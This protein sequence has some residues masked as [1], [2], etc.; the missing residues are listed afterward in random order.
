M[1]NVFVCSLCGGDVGASL[2]FGTTSF[3]GS[4]ASI[5]AFGTSASP[6]FFAGFRDG[7]MDT[8]PCG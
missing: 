8:G 3:F 1:I 6:T 4:M 5:P 7:A 2:G